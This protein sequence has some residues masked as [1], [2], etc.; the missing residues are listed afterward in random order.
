[1]KQQKGFT[2]IELLVVVAILGVIATVAVPNIANFIKNGNDTA[3]KANIASLQSA[4]D[5]FATDNHGI[6]PAS[7]TELKGLVPKY[8]RS[9]PTIGIY[10][11]IDGTV[12]GE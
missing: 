10:T 4:A 12:H 1:M 7:E 6:Y 9:Y 11:I 2:L 5:A 8:L 3:I